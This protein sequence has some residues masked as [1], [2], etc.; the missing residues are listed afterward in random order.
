MKIL[1]LGANGH[2]GTVVVQQALAKGWQV[3]GFVRPGGMVAE[4]VEKFE[5]DARDAAG[6]AK[7][8]E[9]VDAVISTLGHAVP[10]KSDV[11]VTSAQAVLTALGPNQHFVALTGNGVSNEKDPHQSL[12]SNLMTLAIK[13]LP[14]G[15]FKDGNAMA[16]ALYAS[17]K[18]W[19]LLR[20]VAMSNNENGGYEL[21]YYDE[22]F[23]MIGRKFVA[24]ALLECAESDTW[25]RQA[26]MIRPT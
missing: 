5:G 11:M 19:T 3:R 10:K 6:V 8:L 23:A 14:G 21:G 16:Q 13:L 9:G 26:P 2:V 1:V 20:S 15:V 17:D 22:G 25:T 24:Q 18:N 12:A 4:G 7:A